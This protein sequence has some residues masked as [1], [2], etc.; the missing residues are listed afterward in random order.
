[1]R[2]FHRTVSQKRKNKKTERREGRL[3]QKRAFVIPSSPFLR[4]DSRKQ[5]LKGCNDV[6]IVHVQTACPTIKTPHINTTCTILARVLLYIRPTGGFAWRAKIFNMGQQAYLLTRM[7]P[8][9]PPVFL[10]FYIDLDSS[11]VTVAAAVYE[12]FTGK[13]TPRLEVYPTYP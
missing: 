5:A 12:R 10:H 11:S 6:G 2:D 4:A 13:K 7:D 8:A 3:P 9:T 1:M